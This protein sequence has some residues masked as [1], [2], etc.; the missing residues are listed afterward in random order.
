MERLT[1]RV[2]T[3]RHLRAHRVGTLVAVAIEAVGQ[4]GLRATPSL[5]SARIVLLST[6]FARDTSA[7]TSRSGDS[8]LNE[9]EGDTVAL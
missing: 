2:T 5:V 8:E 4:A 6:S 7:V 9:L 1:Q 3:V